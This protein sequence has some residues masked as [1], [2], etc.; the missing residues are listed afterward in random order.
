MTRSSFAKN[1]NMAGEE[2]DVFQK[3][4]RFHRRGKWISFLLMLASPFLQEL[5][6]FQWLYGVYR[7]FT[8]LIVGSCSPINKKFFLDIDKRVHLPGSNTSI[9]SSDPLH[10]AY[11]STSRSYARSLNFLID[12]QKGFIDV[13]YFIVFK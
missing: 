3:N 12:E 10:T 11:T 7:P 1:F 5:S 9:S 6:I 8:W 4:S 2:G 13:F